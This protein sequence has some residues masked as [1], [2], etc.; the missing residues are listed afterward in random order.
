MKSYPKHYLTAKKLE[1]QL[2]NYLNEYQIFSFYD[3]YKNI[4]CDCNKYNTKKN[5]L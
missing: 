3:T 5:C 4:E 1:H 2:L